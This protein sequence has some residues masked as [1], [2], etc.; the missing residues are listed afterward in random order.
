MKFMLVCTGK[1]FLVHTSKKNPYSS[2]L[3]PREVNQ[4]CA[5]GR[6]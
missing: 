4:Q 2:N 5:W 1:K 3:G 6:L